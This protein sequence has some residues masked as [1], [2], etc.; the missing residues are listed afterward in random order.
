MVGHL[1]PCTPL[2]GLLVMPYTRKQQH[3]I[4]H[5]I[6]HVER[7]LSLL[8]T[9]EADTLEKAL[10]MAE[11]G[12]NTATTILGSVTT[13]LNVIGVVAAV[14]SGGLSLPAAGAVISLLQLG[15]ASYK[16]VQKQRNGEEAKPLSADE[17][18]A[19]QQRLSILLLCREVASVASSTRYCHMVDG[20]L[21]DVGVAEF[22]RYG[23]ARTIKYIVPFL[24]TQLPT[25]QA[26]LNHLNQNVSHPTQL[27][28]MNKYAMPQGDLIGKM[29]VKWAY[30]RARVAQVSISEAGSGSWVFYA[31]SREASSTEEQ[32]GF[33]QETTLSKYGYMV[34]P[35][36][37]LDAYLKQRHAK[38]L[39]NP[40]ALSAI[41]KDITPY[42]CVHMTVTRALVE[43]YLAVVRVSNNKWSLS[44]N[45]YLSQQFGVRCIAECHDD[46]LKGLDISKGDFSGVNFR[47]AD[48]SDCDISYT[49]WDGGH[50]DEAKLGSASKRTVLQGTSCQNLT[51]E[52]SYW[53]DVDFAG[54]DFC[55][56]LLSGAKLSRCSLQHMVSIGAVWDWA[57]MHEMSPP[58]ETFL[59]RLNEEYQAR[60]KLEQRMDVVE[61]NIKNL[62]EATRTHDRRLI[63]LEER[64]ISMPIASS[65]WEQFVYPR[66]ACF[67][68]R[69]GLWSELETRFA[70]SRSTPVVLSGLGGMGKTSLASEWA[71]AQKEAGRYEYVRWVN[72]DTLQQFG[73]LQSWAKAL[74][75]PYEKKS[76][77][78]L[79][80]MIAQK[81]ADKNWLVVFDNVENYAAIQEGLSKFCLTT[82]Q[83]ILITSRDETSWTR[84]IRV[85]VYTKEEALTYI[86]QQMEVSDHRGFEPKA[87]QSLAE[88]LG[89][90]PL[91]LELAMA[92]V[93]LDQVSLKAYQDRLSR[94]GLGLLSTSTPTQSQAQLNVHRAITALWSDG[95]PKLTADALNV[96]RVISFIDPQ[97]S[98]RAV[99]LPLVQNDATRLSQALRL[100]RQQSFVKRVDLVEGEQTIE[101]WSAHRLLQE[102]VREGLVEAFANNEAAWQDFLKDSWDAIAV[103]FPMDVDTTQDVFAIARG[104]EHGNTFLNHMTAI[105]AAWPTDQ[106]ARSFVPWKAEVLGR[107]G[108]GEY[109]V[110]R[111]AKALE[112][113]TKSLSLY[114]TIHGATVNHPDIAVSLG[115]LGSV[116]Y[117]QGNYPKAMEYYEASL[118]MGRVIHGETAN[119]PGIAESLNNLGC[120]YG[121]QD[122][123][124]KATEY[125]EASLAM[126]RVIHGETAN[127]PEIAR[128]LGYLGSM[129]YYQGNYPK[130]IEYY[131]AS[132]A[133]GRAI[134]GATA[135]HPG[136]A[137]SLGYLG[138]MYYSQDNYPKAIEYHEASLAMRRTIHGATANHPGI[139]SSLNGLGNVY[140]SQD[141]YPKAIEYYEASLAMGRVIYG[142]TANHPGIA[143]SLNS[144][145]NVYYSQDNYPKAI[146]YYEASLAMGRVIYG[147]T[148]N[149]PSITESLGHLGS[150]YYCQ[151]NYP[152]AIEYYEAS[153]AMRRAIH[154]ETA[155]HLDIAESLNNLG[156]V[157]D[158]QDNYPKAIEYYEAS[159]AMRRVIH[160]ETSN[161][162]DI[163]RSLG[164]LERAKAKLNDS[165]RTLKKNA[166]S[167]VNSNKATK[168]SCTAMH[169]CVCVSCC[170]CLTIFGALKVCGFF[171]PPEKNIPAQSLNTKD[172]ASGAK[173]PMLEMTMQR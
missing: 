26:V 87:A 73:S 123:H 57:E 9:D 79:W 6:Q 169:C 1:R 77:S 124:P 5:F 165:S 49:R 81:I 62:E 115:R 50:L 39:T 40:A 30:A 25:A 47:R 69:L 27:L 172:D 4:S 36:V 120:V 53:E 135:N 16:F 21:T 103:D 153:L 95:L 133:M 11:Q 18:N 139:A 83:H 134:H 171:A 105:S 29:Y 13:I 90:H 35:D 144:L 92:A 145:G 74:G 10:G 91:A 65:T 101:T 136:I 38:N 12:V 158:S 109:H 163:A 157:Y 17:L 130:A 88:R 110:V 100:L 41:S 150:V 132:L 23:A 82:Q 117:C 32:L 104:V 127:H 33:N 7:V 59:T 149:H 141:N 22:A 167:E 99:L 106:C 159:L 166:T 98:A 138:L 155:N 37:C 96:L 78:E 66:D 162:P 116:Y 63:E 126:M 161:H 46:T 43:A 8:G 143:E 28:T 75:L 137:R 70:N 108:Y 112:H 97:G 31:S 20:L 151:G 24:S 85:D 140:Y 170:P 58:E 102:V 68:P 80:V 156:V 119:H 147:A 71:Y 148:A 128:S 129:Y 60:L 56:A 164:N 93:C 72:M 146:E 114:K 160:S 14:P 122:N 107:V 84:P 67:Q 111:Y 94:H 61:E 173:N 51:A 45:D 86:Q 54:S 19:V 131:E 125:F 15:H 113:L 52:K 42:L 3:Y 76:I 64:Y 168:E 89:Y 118:A 154:G 48:L 152:K 44:L 142:A 2:E 121:S 34:L 55:K